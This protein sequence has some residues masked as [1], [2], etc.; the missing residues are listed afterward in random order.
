MRRSWTTFGLAGLAAI[1]LLLAPVSRP[2]NVENAH[3]GHP[4]ATHPTRYGIYG[5]VPGGGYLAV[6]RN[7]IDGGEAIPVCSESGFAESTKEALKRWNKA[8]GAMDDTA[9]AG[10][11]FEW[12]DRNDCP[13]DERKNLIPEDPNAIDLVDESTWVTSIEVKHQGT[14]F[15]CV[16]WRDG[17]EL[18][19]EKSDGLWRLGKRVVIQ[20]RDPAGYTYPASREANTLAHELGHTI[21]L[22]DYPG[23]SSCFARWLTGSNEQRETCADAGAPSELTHDTAKFEAAC[24]DR[25]M[26]Q[27]G[28]LLWDKSMYRICKHPSGAPVA[29]DLA[30]YSAIYTPGAATDVHVDADGTTVRW[31]ASG[32]HV[33]KGFR[34]TRGGNSIDVP[35]NTQ[36]VVLAGSGNPLVT[37][38]TSAPM[39]VGGT[40]PPIATPT[41]TTPTAPSPPTNLEATAGDRS[42]EIEWDDPGDTSISGYDY[43][44][45][46]TAGV[47]CTSWQPINGATATTIRHTIS[48][49]ANG[50]RLMNGTTYYVKI[51]RAELRGRERREQRGQRH[52]HGHHRPSTDLDAH[53][54]RAGGDGGRGRERELRDGLG[55]GVVLRDV[56]G[57]HG[58]HGHGG[59]QRRLP[60]RLLERRLQRLGGQM[61]ASDERPPHC[62]RHLQGGAD[63]DADANADA[64]ADAG[65]HPD[66]DV[67]PR[68][69]HAWRR[70][71][72]LW[73]R[74]TR[75]WSVPECLP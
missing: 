13:V 74:T 36:S 40:M 72:P 75:G 56:R 6:V 65:L 57:G 62:Q 3:A 51:P 5:T 43:C 69:H 67:R 66:R 33:E 19:F 1:V 4:P 64:D 48:L 44:T 12:H 50:A 34:V 32:V 60:G 49:L 35:R 24:G 47:T 30:D 55:A 73:Q 59:S 9:L 8:F 71:H 31:N 63:A 45:N 61:H 21:G 16:T 11:I 53:D 54:V 7:L 20:F 14:C 68:R 42:I 25:L 52:S 46:T 27:Q 15:A 26:R 58:G 18:L 29:L 41:P 38:L 39:P 23:P 10:P 22:K 2:V 70:D 28:P 17:G 37:T